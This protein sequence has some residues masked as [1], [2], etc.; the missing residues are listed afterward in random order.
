MRPCGFMPPG[1]FFVLRDKVSRGAGRLP[2][3]PLP[4]EPRF[5][6]SSTQRHRQQH[7][8]F[9]ESLPRREFQRFAET[10]AVLD[11]NHR[12]AQQRT[13]LTF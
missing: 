9:H 1:R 8:V 7:D 6:H 3:V 12:S 11:G 4:A 5:G 2:E 10:A 13:F